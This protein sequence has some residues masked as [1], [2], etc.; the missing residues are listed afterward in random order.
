MIYFITPAFFKVAYAP[1]LAIVRMPSVDTDKVK[2][3]PISGTKMRFF[4]KFGYFLWLPV[5]VNTVARV[6]LAYLPPTREPFLVIA[7]TFDIPFC[8]S[9]AII[10]VYIMQGL[11]AVF[12]III[13]I[14]SVVVHEVAHGYA[15]YF[16]G[17]NTAKDQGRLTLNPL[18]HLDPIGSVVLP[19]LLILSKTGFVFGWAKPVP[20]NPNNLRNVKRG[21]LVVAVAGIATNLAIAI[22]FG[23]L[24]R[25][26]LW[27]GIPETS[28]FFTV[29]N[30]IVVVNLVLAVFNLVPIPPLDGSKILF[31]L[32]PMKYRNVEN[33]LSAYSFIVLIAFITLGWKYI[34]PII[35]FLYRVIVGAVF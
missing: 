13:L 3:L 27:Y 10:S 35:G 9:Y 16:F 5:G 19:L 28:G 34:L 26:G 31:T 25:L 24:I 2:V 8:A 4:C 23:I 17:D 11:D 21:T 29:T 20:Y 18:K 12:Y 33:F 30:T 7:Q 15:A 14:M 6:R 22:F 1:F 32:L